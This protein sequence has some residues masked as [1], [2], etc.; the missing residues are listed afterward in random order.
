MKIFLSYRRDDTGGR[1]GRLF[2]VLVTRFGAGNVFQD[3]NSAAPGFDFADRVEQAIATSD[4]VLVVIGPS[5]LDSTTADG[6]RRIDQP[7]DFVRHELTSALASGMPVVPVLVDDAELPPAERLPDDVRGL[8]RRQAVSVRDA[9]WRQDV[10][11]LIRRLEGREPGRSTRRQPWLIAG[12]AVV[13]VVA[14]V[15]AIVLISSDDDNESSDGDAPPRCTADSTFTE[16]ELAPE[17]S[18]SFLDEK[19]LALEAE[20]VGAS[21]RP[22]RPADGD[23]GAVLVELSVANQA[24]PE[25]DSIDDDTY[26]GTGAIESLLLDGVDQGDVTCLSVEGDP[27]IEPTERAIATFGFDT[28]ADPTGAPMRLVIYDG[29]ELTVVD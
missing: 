1:A 20:I 19:G 29:V 25:P 7:D 16:I 18:A 11:D 23:H 5:W 21:A 26:L 14:V 10:D 17:R 3:V 24:E 12:I 15:V 9:S 13:A 6:R 22:A 27:E 2:D 8:V 4:A 28:T